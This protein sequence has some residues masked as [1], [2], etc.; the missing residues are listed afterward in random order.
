V[1]RLA[2][3]RDTSWVHAPASALFMRLSG[4]RGNSVFP[5][6]GGAPARWCPAA[7]RDERDDAEEAGVD[8][9]AGRGES[10]LTGA[11]SL[12]RDSS[13]MQLLP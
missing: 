13:R 11:H 2:L 10:T 6:V 5:R 12:T 7:L 4:A 8:G 1:L 9:D 3:S